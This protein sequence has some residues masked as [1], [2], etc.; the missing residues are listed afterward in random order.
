MEEV[1]T[2]E[3]LVEKENG[4][5][6]PFEP[7]YTDAFSDYMRQSIQESERMSREALNSAASVIISR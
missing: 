5:I 2:F 4:T 6:T 7:D 3:A 1:M